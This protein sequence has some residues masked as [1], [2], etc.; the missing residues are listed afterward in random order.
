VTQVSR[1]WD[2]EGPVA[3]QGAIRDLADHPEPRVGS[4]VEPTSSDPLTAAPS[5]HTLK[6]RTTAAGVGR[7]RGAQ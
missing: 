5:L 3:E 6:V 1:G 7:R 4:V 2:S